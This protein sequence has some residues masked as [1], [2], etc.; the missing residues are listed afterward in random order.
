MYVNNLLPIK[1]LNEIRVQIQENENLI[2]K[3]ITTTTDWKQKDILNQF[4]QFDSHIKQLF[5]SYKQLQLTESRLEQL[6][7]IEKMFELFLKQRQ[8]I[9]EQVNKGNNENAYQMYLSIVPQLDALHDSLSRLANEHAHTAE[10]LQKQN[11][12]DSQRASQLNF[13]VILIGDC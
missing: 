7:L 10:L 1:Y 11:V 8:K 13:S 2:L 12:V 4:P 9:F 6:N 5:A 3:L